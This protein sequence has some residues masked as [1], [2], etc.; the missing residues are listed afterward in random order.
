MCIEL[1]ANSQQHLV[2]VLCCSR[3]FTEFA[4]AQTAIGENAWKRYVDVVELK[5]ASTDMHLGEIG[6]VN[7]PGFGGKQP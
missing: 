2:D 7:T 3:L 1:C 5:V 4:S 6:R